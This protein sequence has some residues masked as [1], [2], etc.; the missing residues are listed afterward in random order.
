[1][2]RHTTVRGRSQR[3]NALIELALMSTLLLSLTLGV[4]DF[5]R[6]FALGN[7]AFSAAAAGTAY[8]ALSPAHYSDYAGMQ[9]AALNDAGTTGATAAATRVCYCAVGG[10]TVPCSGDPNEAPC[11]AGETRQTYVQVNVTIP[12]QTMSGLPL[13]PGL[14]QVK[15]R[16]IVRVE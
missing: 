9:T 13:L 5:G 11:A 10:P 14:T 15:G 2:M 7:K 3:G 6:I 8:A 1:M 16:S 4:T 12:F